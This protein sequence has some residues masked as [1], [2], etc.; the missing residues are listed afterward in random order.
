M[1]LFNSVSHNY[2]TYFDNISIV[3]EWISDVICRAVTGSGFSKRQ[4]YTDDEDIIYH[5]LR[6]I[7]LNGINMGAT[8]ADLLDRS[9]IILLER[10]L[11]EK[12]KR[13]EEIWK[14][15]NEIKSQLLG[16]I[17]DI[18]VKV[19]NYKQQQGS[20]EFSNGFN[21]MADWEEYAEII[22]RCMGYQQGEFLW[23]I[24]KISTYKSMRQLQ[25]V[26]CRWQ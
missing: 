19:L 24:K 1:N 25:L 2:I 7:G 11:K 15:F 13:S 5:F 9:I 8:K 23:F 6:C 3:K 4:L 12:R 21:R 14:K 10:I 22:S 16:Y 17:F 20:I 26:H 18:I